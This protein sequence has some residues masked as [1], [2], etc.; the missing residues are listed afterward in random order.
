MAAST[1][2]VTA[3]AYA[4]PAEDEAEAEAD[5]DELP[6]EEV[7]EDDVL[8]V[9]DLPLAAHEAREAGVEALEGS[10]ALE[11][12]AEAGV[13]A[14]EA[15][16]AVAAEVEAAGKRGVNRGFGAYVLS[17]LA[18]ENR[19]KELGDAIKARKKEVKLSD[20]EK[21]KLHGKAK[22]AHERHRAWS[23]AVIA[24]RKKLLD[25]GK[26]L[27]FAW[28]EHHERHKKELK[29]ARKELQQA[30]KELRRGHKEAEDA[31]D[32]AEGA[33][34]DA[35]DAVEDVVDDFKDKGKGKGKSGE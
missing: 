19:G 6:E 34:D 33:L 10:E 9:I 3:G 5:A 18:A 28:K 15:A 27:R 14:A 35:E 16:D 12:D 17:E 2:A 13:S 23:K 20:E 30:R 22:P 29:A 24:R 11:A 25:E 1:L 8:A 7:L 31:L 32:D 26:E 4:A 21:E